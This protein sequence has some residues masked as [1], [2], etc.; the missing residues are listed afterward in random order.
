MA[1]KSTR[2]K[3][4]TPPKV[5]IKKSFSL[6][7]RTQDFIFLGVITVLLLIIL[8][9][10]VIDG[11][12][13]QGV[14]VIAAKGKSHQILEYNKN[15]DERALWNPYIFS[16]MPEYH[17][18]GPV[19][20]SIDNFL[21]TLSKFFSSPFIYYLVG[22]LGIYLLL[23]YLKFTPLIALTGALIFIL[24]PHYKSLW[25]EG[26]F[27]KFRAVLYI[28]WI[29]LTFKHFL[30]KRSILAAALFALSFG[31][32]IRTQHYQIVFY[33]GLLIFAI[34]LY[35]FLKDLFEKRFS[36][37]LKS[38]ILLFIALA[39][40]ITMSAQPLFLA[41]EYL[42]YSK[43]GKTTIDINTD[44]SNQIDESKSDGVQI[45]YATQW[46][47][48]PSELLTWL[49]PRFY[50]GMSAEK[51]MG[52]EVRQARGQMI[53]SYW[54]YMPMT[55][56]Y[57]YMG[58][59]IL[60]LA[61]IGLYSYRK[62][63]IIISLVIFGFF[64]ILLSFGR[65]FQSF[66][67][68]FFH[69]VPFFNKFRAPMMSVTVIS[70]IVTILAAFGMR[71]LSSLHNEKKDWKSYKNLF[72]ILGGFF[73]VGIL[74]WLFSQGFSFVKEAGE[75]YQGQN[76][77]LVKLIRKEMFSDD[78]IR[79]LILIILS[80]GVLIGYLMKK[81]NFTVL[82][83][84]LILIISI[85]LIN[86]QS[87]VNKEF[88]DIDK[89]ERQYFKKTNTDQYILNDQE[90]FRIFPTGQMFSDNRWV[91]SHQTIGGYTPIKMYTIEELVEKNIYNGSDKNLP[92][93][94]NVLKILNVKYLIL[95]QQLEN[96]NIELV[97]SDEKTKIN[98]YE[99]RDYLPRGF[100][101]NKYQI[102]ENEFE[103]IRTINTRDFD[104]RMTAILEKEPESPIS[105]PDSAYANL[106]EFSPNFS[107]Y[108]VYTDKQALFVI[109]EVDYPPGWKVYIDNKSG[110]KLYRTN[111][112][113]Q[114]VVIPE[115]IHSVELKFE[116]DS[117]TRNVR[118]SYASLSI[119]YLIILVFFLHGY[120][121]H[122]L[123]LI[124]K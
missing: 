103:R 16:G 35:P 54:G 7:T 106:V 19:A 61:I 67:G 4:T 30:D 104:P 64:L 120:K 90:V 62:E 115:G 44:Q 18:F 26:H 63:K 91:Y 47:T 69:Y 21:V 40:S 5:E 85:D 66:Y 42:P 83:I 12:S 93:N 20:Y 100:F 23:R 116:P 119:L 113:V 73:V 97:N 34:G 82:G 71:Y 75:R 124:K 99:F 13:P 121:D 38:T 95:Q 74:I 78:L 81:I 11:L 37:F 105:A 68:L 79:Y 33:T 53:S 72:F 49:I 29:F 123:K 46:S 9:P 48:A 1:K 109:S 98:T 102:I 80:A 101:V 58:A 111:H 118:I 28:P 41:K 65:H 15:H 56:S 107:K 14:D 50:G 117:F 36:I 77:E 27:R 110:H 84:I 25:L 45:E 24:M 31:I 52:T 89:L 96:E 59:V 86:V 3:K 57:E 8:K 112:A 2:T 32:Q 60:L 122:L 6:S 76:L 114:S 22:A 39:L 87:R 70:F 17:N 94:W 43:R 10:M 92:I 88:I 51:Y 108:D 55:Q